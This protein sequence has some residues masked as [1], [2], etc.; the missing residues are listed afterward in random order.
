MDIFLILEQL[1]GLEKLIHIGPLLNPGLTWTPR[2]ATSSTKYGL[3]D[4]VNHI[5][6]KGGLNL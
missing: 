4:R 6:Y 5:F 2:T 1:D 3:R